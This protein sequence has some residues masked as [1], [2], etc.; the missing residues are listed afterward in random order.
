MGRLVCCLAMSRVKLKSSQGEES[1]SPQISKSGGCFLGRP[2]EEADKHAGAGRI[3][4]PCQC[5]S[6]CVRACVCTSNLH[7]VQLLVLM[8]YVSKGVTPPLRGEHLL[9]SEHL[10]VQKQSCAPGKKL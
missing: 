4:L 2:E 8:D 3:P 6:T 5:V 7:R 10:L 1:C 9:S